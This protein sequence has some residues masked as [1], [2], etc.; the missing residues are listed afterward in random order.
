M[1]ACSSNINPTNNYKEDTQMKKDVLFLPNLLVEGRLVLDGLPENR[2][3]KFISITGQDGA[4]KTSLRDGLAK[5]YADQGFVVMTSKSPCDQHIV[6]FLNHA[7]S[8]N[9]YEDW[10]TEELLFSF[11]DGLLSNFMIQLN[12]HVDYFICQRGPM[13]QYAHGVTRSGKTYKEMYEVQRPERLF[14]FDV[15]LHMNCNPQVAW[16]RIKNDKGKD[17]YEFPKYFTRQTVNTK[18]LYDDIVAGNDPELEFL[19]ASENYYID[20]TEMTIEEVLKLAIKFLK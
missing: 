18:K 11:C 14:K 5:Y 4:G 6:D 8:Q 1:D 17:R 2:E 3:T 10:Y 19:R 9:G 7:I 20:T 13:D 16:D 15:Y 12:G